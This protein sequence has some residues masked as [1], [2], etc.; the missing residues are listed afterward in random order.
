MNRPY[1]L[2][3]DPLFFITVAFFAVLT[4]AVPGLLGQPRF[5]PLV[6]AVSLGV[7]LLLPLRRRDV[8]GALTVVYLWLVLSMTTLLV[9][10]W[11]APTQLERAIANGFLHRAAISEWYFANSPLPASP[12]AAPLASLV[13][14]LGVTLGSWL[15]AG[16][17]GAWFLVQMAN[18]AAFSAGHLLGIFKNP[19]LLPVALPIWSLLELIGA[20]GLVVLLAEPLANGRLSLGGIFGARRRLTLIFAILF[21][22]GLLL[23]WLLPPYWHFPVPV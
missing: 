10:T 2:T 15:T 5:M 14:V 19:L 1:Q 6:Q 21:A 9:L 20:A 17:L 22:A 18:L 13:E 11:L 7:F 16:F 23:E 8:N 4:T 12:A 3:R